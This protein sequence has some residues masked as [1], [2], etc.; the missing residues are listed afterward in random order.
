MSLLEKS[1]SD[2]ISAEKKG[3]RANSNRGRGKT[4]AGPVRNTGN[5]YQDKQ[6]QGQRGRGRGSYTPQTT[7]GRGARRGRGGYESK[8]SDN[9]WTHNAYQDD[10]GEEEVERPNNNDSY[11]SKVR[12]SNLKWD[13]L[14][15][16]LKELFGRVGK[17]HSVKVH[18]DRAGR[19]NGTAD[20]IFL[21][22][23]DALRSIREYNGRKIDDQAMEISELG[24]VNIVPRQ[25]LNSFGP[26]ISQ[27]TIE[28][29]SG[30]EETFTQRRNTSGRWHAQEM[31]AEDINFRVNVSF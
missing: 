5:R 2:L 3:K 18:Y 25:P 10:D 4:S 6:G 28:I 7:R 19:S 15:D 17:V 8:N 20:V 31:E 30:N 12:V 22:H 27:Q 26:R 11:G 13:V 29:D 9:Q 21:K 24:S 16:E 23:S 1:L 14:E